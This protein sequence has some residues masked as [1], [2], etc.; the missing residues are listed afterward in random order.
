MQI[1][2]TQENA[3]GLI[4]TA[5]RPVYGTPTTHTLP[6]VCH[7]KGAQVPRPVRHS[8]SGVQKTDLKS[9]PSIDVRKLKEGSAKKLL[10]SDNDVAR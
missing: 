10:Y 6:G 5:A 8:G 7:V 9:K 3:A 4:R 2:T 1:P